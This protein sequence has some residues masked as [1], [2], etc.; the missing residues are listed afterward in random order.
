MERK[1]PF[2]PNEYYHSYT[3]GVEKRKIFLS[4]FDYQRFM[5]LLYI[6][7]QSENFTMR[8]FL[9]NKKLSEI[10]SE[11]RKD[12]LVSILS[13][14]LM[15][16]HFHLLLQEKQENGISKFM[17]RLLTAYSMYFNTKNKRSG[18][19]FVRPFRSKHIDDEQHY[20]HIFSYIH[21]NPVD[22]KEKDWKEN[23]PKDKMGAKNFI[24]SYKYSSYIDYKKF[25]NKKT[26]DR[27]ENKILD[28]EKIPKYSKEDFDI[29]EYFNL[30]IESPNF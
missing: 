9:R 17:M 21:L 23:G 2:V 6:M 22:L 24:D 18:P 29:D 15:P 20:L 26:K 16:N 25:L 19:L 12:P 5:A 8:N 4:D 10:Y 27:P 3:R 13:Y 28:W 30:Q 11:K 1:T 7:N 14:C